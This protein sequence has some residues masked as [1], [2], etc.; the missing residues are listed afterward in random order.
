MF[1]FL[2][3]LIFLA[4]SCTII[5]ICTIYV[6]TRSSDCSGV[7]VPQTLADAQASTVA[8]EKTCYCNANLLAAL[9]DSSIQTFCS[10]EL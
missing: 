9:T 1:A 3:I 4:I 8:I 5:G 7:T 6:S 2:I 10:D